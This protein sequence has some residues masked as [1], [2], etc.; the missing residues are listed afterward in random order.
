MDPVTLGLTLFAGL[1]LLGAL[2]ETAF[3]RTRIPDVVWLILAGVLLG[4]VLGVVEREQLTA[5][6][7]G[8]A[9]ITLIIVLFEGGSRLVVRDLVRAAGRA[10]LLSAT[11]FLV[12]VLG[13][14]LVSWLVG[15]AFTEA[16]TFA[17]GIMLGAIVG[18]SSA[19]IVMPSMTLG[20]VD[21]DVANVVSVES[22]LTDALCVV[23]TIAMIGIIASGQASL[24]ESLATLGKQF[25]IAAVVGVAAGWCWMP[26]MR[27]LAGNPHAYP[28]TLSAL[29]AVY[30]LV[31]YL[32]GSSALGILAF[33][34]VVG[35]APAL[36]RLTGFT[37][38]E[39]A[40]L[41]LSIRQIHSSIAFIVKT[42][43]FTFIGLMIGPPW[44]LVAAGLLLG[45]LLLVLR[46]PVVK[47]VM[48]GSTIP[49]HQHGI[50]LV[51][52]P[53]GMAAGV[54]ATMPFQAG[55][56]GTENLP[57]LVFSAVLAS[58]LIFAIGFPI[59]QKR[60]DASQAQGEPP[61]EEASAGVDAAAAA[62]SQPPP[63]APASPE[64]GR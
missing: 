34:I 29:I 64:A 9:A 2:G 1:I 20:G 60:A 56:A 27:A 63:A 48:R 21:E 35:N 59:A 54:L 23:V 18:G 50:V 16:W 12:T 40:E 52:L 33:A 42:L 45:G 3:A 53:R 17:H 43:F 49:S 24:G 28:V 31:Q 46:Y 6:T 44:G 22:A 62:T 39:R 4:P 36:L 61:A 10:T 8:F 5:I 47:L 51:A 41:E 7:P 13:V 15:L 37:T 57:S 14:A 38:P 26:V 32:G 30:A 55:L 19:L 11:G 58:I 25:S